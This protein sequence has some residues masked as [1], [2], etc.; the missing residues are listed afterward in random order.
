MRKHVAQVQNVRIQ[1]VLSYSE[2]LKKVEKNL[3][4]GNKSKEIIQHKTE[5]AKEN[6]KRNLGLRT[7]LHLSLLWLK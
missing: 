3:E 7:M 1:E 6:T 5:M 2:A 4:S